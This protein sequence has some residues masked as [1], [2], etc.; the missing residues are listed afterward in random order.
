[1]EEGRY[2][3]E[4]FRTSRCYG[5]SKDMGVY[6]RTSPAY[7]PTSPAYSPS[8]PLLSPS[9]MKDDSVPF[10]SLTSTD[11]LHSEADYNISAITSMDLVSDEIEDLMEHISVPE[12]EATMPKLRSG[13]AS[14]LLDERT[15]QLEGLE[16]ELEECYEEL[17]DDISST[18][19]TPIAK[20]WYIII[21]HPYKY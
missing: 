21:H 11:S 17:S 19:G 4:F 14:G 6:S 9:A 10:C 5:G 13:T 16:L 1:M 2:S 20:C 12:P 3:D 7:S 8:S 15:S 18:A